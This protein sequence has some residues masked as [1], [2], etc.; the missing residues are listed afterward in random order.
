MGSNVPGPAPEVA[1]RLTAKERRELERT[2]RK[3]TAAQRDVLRARIVLLAAEGRGNASIAREV[4]CA[5]NTVRAWRRRFAERGREGLKDLPRSGRPPTYGERER[6]VVTAVAC[7]L[8]A[9]RGLPLSRFSLADLHREARRELRPCPSRSTIGRWLA[10]DAIKPWQHRMWVTPRA[11][12][13]REKAS[14]V[15][16]LYEGTW[17]G[18][19]LGKGDVVLCGDEKTCLQV[20]RRAVPTRPP[21]PGCPARVEHEYTRHGV[22]VYQAVLDVGTGKV[23]GQCVR[24]NTKRVFRRLVGRV[25]AREPCRS[26]RRVFWILDN[27]GAHDSR[28]FPAWLAEHHPAAVPVFLPVHASWISECAC[29]FSTVQRKALTPADFRD[30]EELAVRVKGFERRYDATAKP[31]RWTFTRR[32]LRELLHRLGP[33]GS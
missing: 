21:A 20:L 14:R 1:I 10:E 31:F 4:A 6:L 5:R 25:M 23:C 11:P 3:T 26:A 16:D 32:D 29:Y 24:R 28:T 13:F 30:R 18:K 17:R 19:P 27:G 9:A 33:R 15:L 12:D 8:S 7:E 2:V 22:L